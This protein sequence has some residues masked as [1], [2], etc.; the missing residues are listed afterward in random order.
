MTLLDLSVFPFLIFLLAHK[1]LRHQ[2]LHVIIELHTGGQCAGHISISPILLL[3]KYRIN[4]LTILPF[5]FTPENNTLQNAL[6]KLRLLI[7]ISVKADILCS[8][9]RIMDYKFI[10]G[11]KSVF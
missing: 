11:P 2:I 9:N 1:D 5:A 3:N 6:A 8:L 7:L 10:C 4:L